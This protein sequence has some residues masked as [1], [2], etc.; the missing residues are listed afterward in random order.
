M[1][2][3]MKTVED[4]NVPNV[5][6]VTS[7]LQGANKMNTLLEKMITLPAIF[8]QKVLKGMK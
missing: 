7:K 3:L 8:V 5:V 2:L 1:S 6:I 4:I